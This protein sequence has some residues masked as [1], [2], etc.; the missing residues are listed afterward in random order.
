MSGQI[1]V[2]YDEVYGKTAELKRRLESGLH[3]MEAS[4]TR[5]RAALDGMDG[6]TNAAF[7]AAVEEN[8][9]KAAMTAET[10]MKLLSFMENSA[11]EVERNDRMHE[12]VF[13]LS[14]G[15]ARTGGKSGA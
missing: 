12:R 4:Y 13:N 3:E 11:R 6:S 8:R 2:R 5:A 1:L 9:T 10:L 7:S 14:A 15:P